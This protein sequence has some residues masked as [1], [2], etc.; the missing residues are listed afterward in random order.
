MNN[1]DYEISK[2]QNEHIKN[3]VVKTLEVVPEY[4]WRIVASST[5]KYHPQYAL[6][7]G[8]LVRH[9]KAAVA[10]ALCLFENSTVQNFTQEEKDLIV[11]ALI[12]HDV[13][14]NGIPGGKWTVTEHPLLVKE[15]FKKIEWNEEEKQFIQ[16]INNLIETHMG[17]W[18]EDFKTKKK[19]LEKPKSKL[20][21][22]C[23]MADYLASRKFLEVNFEAI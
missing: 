17:Q 6:G 5:S 21:K 8:G 11:A 20:Q 12:L 4:F 13:C 3:I 9:T 18:V 16:I 1:F 19:V 15:L 22:F 23:H 10:I 14:K 2:I 7:E